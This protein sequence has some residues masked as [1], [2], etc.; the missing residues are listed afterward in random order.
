MFADH[1]LRARKHLPDGDAYL[2]AMLGGR[3][4]RAAALYLI[5]NSSLADD[6]LVERWIASGAAAIEESQDVALVAARAILPLM[7]ANRERS[8]RIAAAEADLGARIAKLLFAV[9]GDGVSPD[10]TF[11]LR[12][13]DGRV[14]GY[15]YNGTLAPWRTVFHGMFARSAE[16]DDAHPFDLPRQWQLAADR[17]DM[18]APV[19]FVCTV[20]STGGNSGSPVVNSRLELVGLLFD[21]NIESMGNEFLYGE[22]VERSVCVHPQGIV[23]ALRKVYGA[24]RLL[25]EI[26]R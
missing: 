11:T 4:P 13:S 26:A 7:R 25:R 17:I 22:N 15:R 12:F 10:A 14:A 16:F 3:E 2:R 21:G 20:D 6:D 23:E 9:Y 1:L 24:S 5:E 18:R 19:D 8:Q